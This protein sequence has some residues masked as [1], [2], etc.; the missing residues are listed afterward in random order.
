MH[1]SIDAGDI[2]SLQSS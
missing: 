1:I 2:W